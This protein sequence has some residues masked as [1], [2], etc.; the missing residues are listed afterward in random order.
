MSSGGSSSGVASKGPLRLA[1]FGLGRAGSIHL[2]NIIANARIELVYIVEADQEKAEK[3]RARFNLKGVTLLQPKDAGV[4]FGDASVEACLIATPTFT[5]E[6]FVLSSLEAGK[7]VFCEKP[8]AETGEGTARCYAMAE[9]AGK[10]LFC[11]FNRR[12]DPSFRDAKERVRAGKKVLYFIL[13]G[14]NSGLH[15]CSLNRCGRT[16]EHDQG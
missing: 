8:I 1:L 6:E 3:V 2:S 10:N 11:A 7:D 15:L 9:K 12:F 4:V 14:L 13:L 16:R 5:H